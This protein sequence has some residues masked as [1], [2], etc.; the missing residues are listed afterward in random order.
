MQH[1]INGFTEKKNKLIGKMLFIQVG[2]LVGNDEDT[3][4]ARK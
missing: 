2:A 3:E 1:F 4:N